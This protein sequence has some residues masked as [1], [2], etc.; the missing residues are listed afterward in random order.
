MKFSKRGQ[1]ALK[2]SAESIVK[3][4]LR[5]YQKLVGEADVTADKNVTCPSC[6]H[7]FAVSV[8][9]IDAIIEAFKAGSELMPYVKPKLLAVAQGA[10]DTEGN[11]IST[12]EVL[13]LVELAHQALANE[14]KLL[15]EGTPLAAL[16]R[17]ED[18]DADSAEL[19]NT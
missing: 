7:T 16:P 15:E 17:C 13:R 6:R 1:K 5:L 19:H 11:V 2:R 18:A 9:R 3:N 12:V 14:S 10:L 8:Q 4:Q